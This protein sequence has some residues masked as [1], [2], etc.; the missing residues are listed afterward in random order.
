MTSIGHTVAETTKEAPLYAVAVNADASYV[1]AAGDVVEFEVGDTVEIVCDYDGGHPIGTKGKVTEASNQ[2]S[3]KVVSS[4]SAKWHNAEN[5]KLA[6]PQFTGDYEE[7]QKQWIEH[8]GLKVGDKVRVV[9]KFKYKEN[10]FSC[11]DWDG[12]GDKAGMQQGVY[13]VDYLGRSSI[14]VGGDDTNGQ[15]NFPY[16]ALEPVKE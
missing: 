14:S 4:G 11:G 12:N 5:L 7:C 1:S 6:Q 8:H 10:G 2:C 15:W 3:I 16:F 9:R 13:G